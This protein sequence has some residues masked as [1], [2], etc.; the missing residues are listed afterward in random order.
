[1]DVLADGMGKMKTKQEF[2]DE[3]AMRVFCRVIFDETPVLAREAY[4]LAEV[5]W[6]E[7]ERRI[8]EERRWR[9][10]DLARGGPHP[11]DAW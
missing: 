10:A 5:L 8:A 6:A 1:M 3:V 9:E 4:K 11:L 2:F 7:R